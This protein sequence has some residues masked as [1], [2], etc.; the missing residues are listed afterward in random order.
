M[1]ERFRVGVLPILVCLAPGC[2]PEPAAEEDASEGAGV[3]S[4]AIIARNSLLPGLISAGILAPDLL[5]SAAGDLADE[6]GGSAEARKLLQYAASCAL[7]PDQSFSFSWTD[8][9]GGH[10]E[11]Y[12]GRLGLA[13]GWEQAPLTDEKEQRLV[14]ACLAARVNYHGVSVEI[15]IR[16]GEVL[17]ELDVDSDELAAYPHIEGAFWG[18]LFAPSPYVNACYYPGHEALARASLRDC[19]AGHVLTDAN[20]EPTGQIAPCG[21]IALAGPCTGVCQGLDAG[22]QHYVSCLDHPGAADSPATTAVITT[23]LP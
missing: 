5:G 22:G 9:A 12:E 19:A 17:A 16:S 8:A 14:S 20:G 2:V 11:E 18:N 10:E 23:A 3:S 13:P 1:N 15:S 7:A 6:I 4:S 21:M